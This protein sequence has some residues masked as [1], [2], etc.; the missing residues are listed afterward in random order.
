MNHVIKYEWMLKMMS[1]FFRRRM[2]KLFIVYGLIIWLI[3]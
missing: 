3:K 1:F 2:M